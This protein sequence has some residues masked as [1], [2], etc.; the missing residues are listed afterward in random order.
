MSLLFA[1][2]LSPQGITLAHRKDDGAWVVIG[3]ADPAAPKLARDFAQ[4]RKTMAE[5]EG[6]RTQQAGL[7]VIL[8]S[9]LARFDRLA[10]PDDGQVDAAV[11]DFLRTNTPYDLEYLTYR[12]AVRGDQIWLA[13]IALES[14][15]EGLDFARSGGFEPEAV[16]VMPPR[17][18][19]DDWPLFCLED[20]P[21]LPQWIAP[22][23]PRKPALPVAEI[24]PARGRPRAT[25]SWP[26]IHGRIH[27]ARDLLRANARI[28]AKS[29]VARIAPWLRRP[30]FALGAGVVTLGGA[31]LIA[32]GLTLHSAD[33]PSHPDAPQTVSG[34][35]TKLTAIAP[36][37]DPDAPILPAPR[38]ALMDQTPQALP[39]FAPSPEPSLRVIEPVILPQD[40]LAL[41]AP[42]SGLID[43]APAPVPSPAPFG[44]AFNLDARGLVVPTPEGALT[45][46]G[47]LVF[48]GR[49][50]ATTPPRPREVE[51]RA[52]AAIAQAEGTQVQRRPVPRPENFAE[53]L[54]RRRF[55]G[56]T[57][58]EM[59]ERRPTPR[60]LSVQELA[61]AERAAAAAAAA[62]TAG[63]AAA[64]PADSRY[65]VAL[66]PLPLVKPADIDRIVAAAAPPPSAVSGTSR[67]ASGE[68]EAEIAAVSTDIPSNASVTR[69]ATINNRMR[70]DQINLIG[71]TGSPSD[72]RALVRLSSGRFVNVSVGDRLDG[73]RVAAI[74]TDSL[75][76]VKGNDN[77]RLTVPGR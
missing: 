43:I 12:I 3:A 63:R 23:L 30:N 15:A 64:P 60:P 29:T 11:A 57:L 61:E 44:T 7:L 47:I 36:Q 77:I 1:L 8:P 41:I 35:E 59:A 19:G 16:T 70:L 14:L 76:Y 48:A 2:T 50:A 20:D 74:D 71:I 28:L 18:N 46:E 24:A 10:V 6:A 53:S 72:R 5:L 51:D 21:S 68:I 69:A 31:A 67:P 42:D 52:A 17:D 34:S 66:S 56:L 73:G 62:A 45:P 65:A 13:T 39:A 22:V 38:L 58:A 32:L 55:G 33:A 49:P 27:A 25:F 54:E 9:D 26:M 4:M 37:I 75:Q 40:A